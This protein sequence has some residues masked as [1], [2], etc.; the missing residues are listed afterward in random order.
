MNTMMQ[1]SAYQQSQGL[2]DTP[3]RSNSPM[4]ASSPAIGGSP[5]PFSA[6]YQHLPQMSPMM[7]SYAPSPQ[8]GGQPF[9]AYG[10]PNHFSPYASYQGPQA[11]S[12]QGSQSDQGRNGKEEL[13]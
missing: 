10:A 6:S 9:G 8:F 7:P 4:G 13:R 11:G 5:M 12:M 3:S 2:P 1:M